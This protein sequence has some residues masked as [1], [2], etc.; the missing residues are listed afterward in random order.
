LL[1]VF[2][3]LLIAG[4]GLGLRKAHALRKLDALEETIV[5]DETSPAN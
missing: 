4:V 2:V 3:A 5:R 1:W